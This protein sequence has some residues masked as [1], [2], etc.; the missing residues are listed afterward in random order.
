MRSQVSLQVFFTYNDSK[1]ELLS[2][3]VS[4]KIVESAVKELAVRG[5]FY[6]PQANHNFIFKADLVDYCW[7]DNPRLL[8]KPAT[9]TA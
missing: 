2:L 3:S 4:L 6:F 1:K 9:Q 5:K 7:I 8:D